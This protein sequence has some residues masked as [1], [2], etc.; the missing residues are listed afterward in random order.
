MTAMKG[1]I[2]DAELLYNIQRVVKKSPLF[3]RAMWK[4]KSWKDKQI[5]FTAGFNLFGVFEVMIEI[6][7]A[8][9]ILSHRAWCHQDHA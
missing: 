4:G 8:F 2:S 6:L 5:L 9:I 1:F 3:H 7:K